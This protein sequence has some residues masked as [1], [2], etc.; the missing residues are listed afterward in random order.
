MY[1]VDNNVNYGQKWKIKTKCKMWKKLD[2]VDKKCT[3]GENMDKN[4]K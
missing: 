3:Y 4:V 2:N 1:N